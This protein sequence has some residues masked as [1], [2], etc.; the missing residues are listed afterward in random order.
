MNV[1]LPYIECYVKRSFLMGPDSF[2]LSK[3]EMI[4]CVLLNFK[5]VM[6]QAPLFEVYLPEYQACYDKVMQHGLFNKRIIGSG[7][8][9]IEDVAY[10]DCLSDEAELY[11]KPLR[12]H[13][14]QRGQNGHT[15]AGDY[16]FT[17]DW[18]RTTTPCSQWN[19]WHEHKQK[20]F[21]FDESTGVL[22]CGPNNRP[23]Y[24]DKSLSHQPPKKPLF[25]VFSGTPSH[26][27]FDALGKATKW[28][29]D[30]D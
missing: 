6:G 22:V 23:L 8:I 2:I 15:F 13:I 29:Y 3:D 12:M 1:P 18:K 28:N 7:R 17:I 4:P 30:E 16:L 10:W 14:T 20:N 27:S 9:D 19:V 5:A 25:K 21:F 24:Y 11:I 26:E